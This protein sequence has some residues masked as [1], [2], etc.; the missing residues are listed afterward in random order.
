MPC[1]LTLVPVQ[2]GEGLS[3]AAP[4]QQESRPF[5]SLP[6]EVIRD[7]FV[8]ASTTGTPDHLETF[9]F[10]ARLVSKL[11]NAIITSTPAAW[12]YPIIDSYPI[13]RHRIARHMVYRG[14]LPLHVEILVRPTSR[15]LAYRPRDGP[16]RWFHLPT[17]DDL[18]CVRI[19][20]FVTDTSTPPNAVFPLIFL[21]NIDQTPG[22]VNIRSLE[23]VGNGSKCIKVG[24][25]LIQGF[26]E[27]L[28]CFPMLQRLFLDKF[29]FSNDR[30][31]IN[32][33]E[34]RRTLPYLRELRF[35]GV[36]SNTLALLVFFTAPLLDTIAIDCYSDDV[37]E[38]PDVNPFLPSA[39]SS[40]VVHRSV[41]KVLL[42]NIPSQR[43][44]VNILSIVPEARHLALSIQSDDQILEQLQ[45][46]I[47]R[48]C[49]NLI[50][51]AVYPTLPP[52]PKSLQTLI[53]ARLHTLKMLE[54]GSCVTNARMNQPDFDSL[55]E[56][57]DLRFMSEKEME[58]DHVLDRLRRR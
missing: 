31:E 20:R 37:E 41:R 25:P 29:L 55:K 48:L 57:V 53:E 38:M 32:N 16:D 21:L 2:I 13:W 50:S 34:T 9:P 6:I 44:V 23:L 18:H 27:F 36:N 40:N 7:I 51:L 58:F 8:I 24:I 19:L 3:T 49:L 35:K 56:H 11:W 45:P 15:I 12:T 22:W 39:I 30:E 10:I 14:D 26:T 54:L 52:S 43:D 42:Y 47:K 5:D 33:D 17:F 1:H 46:G 28:S 4:P